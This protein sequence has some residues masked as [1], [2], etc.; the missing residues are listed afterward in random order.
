MGPEAAPAVPAL[1]SAIKEY[2]GMAT[3]TFGEWGMREACFKALGAMGSA[4]REALPVLEGLTTSKSRFMRLS[5]QEAIA[6]IR[7]DGSVLARVAD[8]HDTLTE[9][10][11]P[12]AR[13]ASPDVN[14]RREAVRT[15]IGLERYRGGY[16]RDILLPS[17]QDPDLE[18]RL[19]AAHAIEECEKKK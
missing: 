12:T 15:I 4:G 13:L 7:A 18:V 19:L 1:L 11:E 8:G 16:L 5:A 17:L 3:I 6:K 2:D 9:I 14:V 10:G